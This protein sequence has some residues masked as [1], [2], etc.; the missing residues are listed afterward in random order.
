MIAGAAV[1]L[2]APR[3][4]ALVGLAPHGAVLAQ[5]AAVAL[6]ALAE[7]RADGWACGAAH[8]SLRRLCALVAAAGLGA[9]AAQLRTATV[10][11]AALRRRRGAG[12]GR[13]LGG[14]PTTPASDG[15]R[16]RLLVRA[17]RRRRRAA[18]LCARLRQPM[19]ACCRRAAPRAAA[20]C[21]GRPQGRWRL[22]R[23]DF[24][25]RAYFE[26]LGATG[27]AF[28]RCRPDRLRAAAR[29]GS[30]ASACSWRRCAPISP[31]RSSAAAPG[32]GG[33]HRR[34]AGHRRPQRRSTPTPTRRCAIPGLGICSRFRHA[35]GRRRRAWCSRLLL[36]TLVADRADR[37]ALSGE[38]D[39]RGRRAARAG[40]Y[41]VISGASVPALR[42]VRDGGVAFGAIL[43][44]RPAISMR[45]LALAA[46][47]VV[48]LFPE[49]VLEPGFQM[50]FAAT[51][52][53]VALFEMLKRAPHEPALPTPGP[54]IGALQASDARH[55][56]RAR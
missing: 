53:L 3:R 33:A 1:W 32:R 12:A 10:A 19:P 15:P 20:P 44:D 46:L 28:G 4:P 35:H 42:V 43:L 34:G 38:E 56:R 37:V 51:M 45:G 47:I 41:L 55:R 40:A 6:A 16:L 22:A 9:G 49:S 31:P 5:R 48:L 18:A 14:R 26:R 13:G 29:S 21:S 7:R 17:H 54:L 23:Y 24:A 11:A 2:T 36:W 52:A 30:I 8:A 25:R 27:F 50:S 39:R